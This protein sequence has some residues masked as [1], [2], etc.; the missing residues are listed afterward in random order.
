MTKA[1]VIIDVQ[2]G[3]WGHPDHPPYDDKGVLER[4]AALIAKARA[5]GVTA[6]NEREVW[7]CSATMV[8][9]VAA[10]VSPVEWA[11]E[12]SVTL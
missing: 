3:M 7:F 2:K 10:G 11:S 8:A 9:A 6:P 12:T 5:A 1:L 4:I